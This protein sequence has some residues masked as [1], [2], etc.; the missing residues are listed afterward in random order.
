MIKRILA[1][2]CMAMFLLTMFTVTASAE[3]RTEF[4]VYLAGGTGS[5]FNING[6]SITNFYITS[7]YDTPDGNLKRAEYKLT[8]KGVS[9]GMPYMEVYCYDENGFLLNVV[10]FKHIGYIDMHKDTA[11]IEFV[12]R[13]IVPQSQTF[14][15][16]KYINVYHKDGT[17]KGIHDLM[18]SE[19]LKNG[20][21]QEPWITMYA[22][23]NGDFARSITVLQSE[24]AAY[25]KVGWYTQ[26]DV[27]NA[28]TMYAL[29]SK[30]MK[31]P[32]D[33]VWLYEKLGWSRG[34][35]V[36]AFENGEF[37]RPT[38]IPSYELEAYKNVGWYTNED[39]ENAVEM[40]APPSRT[41]RVPLDQVWLY[42]IL[43]WSKKSV[44]TLGSTPTL[45]Y[46]RNME[47]RVAGYRLFNDDPLNYEFA[48]GA[49]KFT[50]DYG[51]TVSFLVG[52]GDGLGEDI[53][54]SIVAGDPWEV[55]YCFGI[56]VFPLTF[57]EGLYSPINRYVDYATNNMIDR[58]TV[59]G[60]KWKGNYY[61]IS[62]LPMQEMWYLA[63]NET[64]MK[65]LGLKTP[66]EYYQEGNWTLESYK[67]LN[68]KAV[69]LGANSRSSVSR[70]HTGSRFMSEWNDKT[71]EVKVVYDQPDNVEWLSFWGALLTDSKYNVTR[72]GLVSQR[73]VIMRDEVMPNLIKDELTQ[74]TTD[75]VRYIH[76]PNPNGE[77]GTYLTDSHFIFPLGTTDAELPYAV[78]LASYMSA[79]K[80]QSNL[81][82]YSKNMMSEDFTLF[83]AN[84]E[85][86]YY[87]PR[88]FYKGVFEIGNTFRNDMA[89]GKS[90]AT[91]IAEQTPILKARANEFNLK[92]AD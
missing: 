56:S 28:I 23:E 27:E 46:N 33:L 69:A 8:Y 6:I 84:M 34:V 82:L 77:L 16:Q 92:Y 50:E 32:L 88:I 2:I 78:M 81:D 25:K 68:A 36:Y 90:V 86:A 41:M 37:T 47:L 14:L 61:G 1:I 10:D 35:T 72:S 38:E 21:T 7:V 91:H 85:N 71:G 44:T 73:N 40:C 52:G 49:E 48:K 75:V 17:A 65:E 45:T 58:I 53:V 18:L 5:V 59:E 87:L 9:G 42:E 31:A 66:Y 89:A 30:T 13:N 70:P 15:Y 24:A 3:R 79:E 64:W 11:M 62:S 19:Y 39:I 51:A 55:Q 54:A 29:P 4:P 63:Y 83:N 43:G 74:E 12:P 67:E 26:E 57:A 20:W 60:T 76:F 80:G 22:Y